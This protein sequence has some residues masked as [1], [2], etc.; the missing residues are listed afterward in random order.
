[1]V[2]RIDLNREIKLT[3]ESAREN[4]PFLHPPL[5]Y[6]P[7]IVAVGGAEPRGWKQMSEDFLRL[8][9]ERSVECEYLEVP[10]AHHYSL[11]FHLS[12]PASP[13]ARA[14]F[15]QMGLAPP[16]KS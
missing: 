10:D 13:L 11:S 8:C 2:L 5:P 3:P 4:S 12:D 7:L 16:A 14:I 6:T 1:A 15:K 9:K